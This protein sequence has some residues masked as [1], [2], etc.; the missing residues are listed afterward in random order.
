MFLAP[1]FVHF[2]YLVDVCQFCSLT[3]TGV[4]SFAV[5]TSAGQVAEPAPKRAKSGTVPEKKRP[6][7]WLPAYACVLMI[8][9]CLFDFVVLCVDVRECQ[10]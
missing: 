10:S 2:F 5:E 8:F 4:G 7:F 9:S 3:S 6:S 1:T